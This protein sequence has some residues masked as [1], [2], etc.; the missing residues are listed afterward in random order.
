MYLLKSFLLKVYCDKKKVRTDSDN[1][2]IK[3][4]QRSNGNN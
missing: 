4:Y 3:C 2:G 1:A